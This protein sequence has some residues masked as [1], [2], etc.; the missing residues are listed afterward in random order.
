MPE[1]RAFFVQSRRL[2][3]VRMPL[4]SKLRAHVHRRSPMPSPLPRRR[5]AWNPKHKAWRSSLAAGLLV[6]SGWPPAARTGRPSGPSGSPDQRQELRDQRRS[7]IWG[8][9]APWAPQRRGSCSR[10]CRRSRNSP[11]STR[12]LRHHSPGQRHAH[13]KNLFRETRRRAGT[14]G[15]RELASALHPANAKAGRSRAGHNTCA[16]RDPAAVGPPLPRP[17]CPRRS[18]RFGLSRRRWLRLHLRRPLRFPRLF[19]MM[20]SSTVGLYA[21]GIRGAP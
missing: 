8:G 5:T 10:P 12:P 16:S 9:A 4:P 1:G 21:V 13:P 17:S 7:G 3:V 14:R 6:L 18:S 20:S 2:L 11:R 15:S 19:L